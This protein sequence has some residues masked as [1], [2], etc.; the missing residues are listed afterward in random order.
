[1]SHRQKRP[2][3][4]K[5]FIP[6]FFA[7]TF[8][9]SA[10]APAQQAVQPTPA[11]EDTATPAPTASAT[12]EPSATPAPTFTPFPTATSIPPPTETPTLLPTLELPTQPAF[13]PFRQTWQSA[14]SLPDDSVRDLNFTL[15]YDPDVWALTEDLFGAQ[16]LA[17]RAIPYCIIEKARPGGLSPGYTAE[18]GFAQV[19][20]INYQT[21]SVRLNG[22]LKYV[23]YYGGR[24][25]QA[26]TVFTVSFEEQPET[27]LADAE[28]VLAS[29]HFV[30]VTP[31]P[32]PTPTP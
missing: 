21:I 9:L 25:K 3:M 26:L 6:L 23:N 4:R 13:V 17:H 5:R 29:L 1:M 2:L 15:L 30:V 16:V 18:Q 28:K 22:V 8:I 7:L 11:L 24:G 10:C 20:S 12:L 14:P 27:C 19:G 32:E 31:T